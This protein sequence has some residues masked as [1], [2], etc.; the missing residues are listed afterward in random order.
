M[1]LKFYTLMRET[2]NSPIKKGSV[3]IE[4]NNLAQI[5]IKAAKKVLATEG[6]TVIYEVDAPFY[7]ALSK[8]GD[9]VIKTGD[10]KKEY[11]VFTSK[12]LNA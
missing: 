8:D 3:E 10:N 9:T 1:K 11:V 12:Y 6:A 5:V 4:G 2:A 7:T